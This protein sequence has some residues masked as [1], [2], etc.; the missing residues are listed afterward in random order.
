ML[1]RERERVGGVELRVSVVAC[2]TLTNTTLSHPARAYVF[3]RVVFA[4]TSRVVAR[5]SRS[6]IRRA[7]GVV[8]SQKWLLTYHS[9]W[10][11]RLTSVSPALYIAHWV[12]AI[13]CSAAVLLS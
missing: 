10:V 2:V 7:W 5:T 13:A 9:S 3:V 11:I 6:L 4:R 1:V 12:A 8:G